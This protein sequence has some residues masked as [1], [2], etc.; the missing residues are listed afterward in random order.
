MSNWTGGELSRHRKAKKSALRDAPSA[1]PYGYK[2]ARGPYIAPRRGPVTTRPFIARSKKDETPKPSFDFDFFREQ[3]AQAITS[4]AGLLA[5]VESFYKSD[6]PLTLFDVASETATDEVSNRPYFGPDPI[7]RGSSVFAPDTPPFSFTTFSWRRCIFSAVR[8]F[9]L[10][11]P[12][13]FAC[14]APVCR[15]SPQAHAL[16]PAWYRV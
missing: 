7:L 2:S 1:H 9:E 13:E 3:Q 5:P 10:L 11:P 8:P 4:G 14:L 16:T 6:K 12:G 15:R